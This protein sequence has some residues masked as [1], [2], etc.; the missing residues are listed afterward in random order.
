MIG[1]QYFYW[2]FYNLIWFNRKSLKLGAWNTFELSIMCYLTKSEQNQSPF[3][4]CKII[5]RSSSKPEKYC[6][7]KEFGYENNKSKAIYHKIS[8]NMDVSF[9]RV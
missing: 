5:C 6:D 8:L 7:R 2:D 3:T 9:F 4:N 1:Y